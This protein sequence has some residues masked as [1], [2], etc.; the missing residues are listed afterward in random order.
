MVFLQGNSGTDD[1]FDLS[2]KVAESISGS[3]EKLL[4]IH[5]DAG[6]TKTYS[7][8]ASYGKVEL[9]NVPY[10]TILNK[11]NNVLERKSDRDGSR[12]DYVNKAEIKMN[13]N[14]TVTITNQSYY[15]EYGYMHGGEADVPRSLNTTL[16][17][18]PYTAAHT[19]TRTFTLKE[20]LQLVV[21]SHV[22]AN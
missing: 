19:E 21:D 15:I 3:K 17:F 22:S 16:Y 6:E 5:L 13:G 7:I 14:S 8:P 4:D 9:E 2:V 11:Y 20:L 12:P 10:Y 18:T 1:T